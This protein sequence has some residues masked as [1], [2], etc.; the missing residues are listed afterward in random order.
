MFVGR[1]HELNLLEQ[2]LASD[3]A[4]LVIL[5][6]RRRVGKSTLLVKAMRKHKGTLFFEALQQ[7]PQKKQIEHFLWQ[8]AQQT[9]TPLSA[10]RDWREAFE[11][12]TYYVQ[13]GRHCV[14]LDEFPWMAAGKTELVSLVK[15]F[16]DTR[17][18]NNPRLMLVLCGS[19]AAFMLKH[20]VHSQAL[21]NRK[22][23]EI[24]LQ[25]LPAIEAKRFFKG[26]RSDFE[27][28]KFLM[29]FGGIP[30]YLEQIDPSRSLFDNVNRLC[31]QKHG[32]FLTELETVFKEQFKV[33]RNYERIV[34][35]LSQKSCAKEELADLLTMASGG[36]LTSYI[37]ALEQADFIKTFSPFSVLGK[38][39]KTRRL[40]LWD[41]WLRF[42]FSWVEP[43]RSIIEM[44]TEPGLFDRITGGSLDPYFGLCFEQM[45]IKNL[46]QLFAN[47][48][49]DFHQ[50]LGFGPYFSQRTLKKEGDEGLQID[51]LVCRK[52]RVLTLVECKFTN[53]PV[54]ISVIDEVERKVR[55]LK[56]L[57][58]YTI[59]R[60]L[61]TAGGATAG[62]KNNDYFHQI[63][64]LN[65]LLS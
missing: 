22:T 47:L 48:G 13:K 23:L 25:P 39:R 5:Y 60:V 8:L 56:P 59:E 12:L 54:G 26:Q 33:V 51:L 58:N 37:Q 2:A 52:G 62:L 7:T 65:A 44:N 46:P 15:F 53:E 50:V 35:T 42:Y 30:K 45:C 36:G 10:A 16:W 29:I 64:G 55:F 32:F 49:I 19:I 43:H 31:F 18:K 11:V 24:K 41:E 4:E 34:R 21:H 63:V 14:V 28:A 3:R 6:G 17:W 1:I 57:A 40:V 38:G 27:I 61:I 9:Q 20:I